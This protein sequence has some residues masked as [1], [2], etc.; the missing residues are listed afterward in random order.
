MAKAKITY[1]FDQNGRPELYRPQDDNEQKSVERDPH[2][3]TVPLFEGEYRVLPDDAENEN[4]KPHEAA[5]EENGE[6]V[7]PLHDVSYLNQYTTDFGAW[8]S[9]FDAETEK[10]EK[11]IRETDRLD[12]P[13]DEAS[14]RDKLS[15]AGGT[16]PAYDAPAY[17]S[18][19]ISRYRRKRTQPPWRKLAATFS[20]AVATGAVLGFIVLSLFGGDKLTTDPV[21]DPVGSE[22]EQTDDASFLAPFDDPVL[23]GILNMDES[24]GNT[25]SGSGAETA[26]AIALHLEPETYYVLQNGLFSTSEG[27]SSAQQALRDEGFAGAQVEDSGRF[28]VYAGIVTQYDDALWLSHQLQEQQFEMYIKTLELPAVERVRWA[29]GQEEQLNEYFAELNKLMKMLV[30]VSSLHLKREKPIAPEE[31]TMDSIRKQH[32]LWSSLAN[33][34]TVNAP[35]QVQGIVQR[36]N[37][38]INTAV[39]ALEE[40]AKNPSFAYPWQA[41]TALVKAIFMKKQ[42]LDAIAL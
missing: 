27:A 42:L 8:T 40:Y 16:P 25:G 19:V 39:M 34:V 7:R 6:T 21:W 5:E 3:V 13:H 37:G 41:Q 32:R 28:F 4:M 31:S 15:W 17:G 12:F 10:L 30:D 20:G 24:D 33:V 14:E 9:P 11:L 23:Q 18:P 29:G 22:T 26:D 36:M 2:G 38:E 1:R 35:E